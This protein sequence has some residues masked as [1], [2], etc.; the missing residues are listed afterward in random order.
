[1]QLSV[2]VADIRAALAAASRVVERRNT[3]P[4]LS[5]VRLAAEGDRLTI[6]ATDLDLELRTAIPAEI[7]QPGATALPGALLHDIVKKLGKSDR[8]TIAPDGALYR[9]SSGRSKW[10]LNALSESDFPDLTAGEFPT[11]FSLPTASV[12]EIADRLSFAIS[13]EE[14]RY[15]LN[16]VYL[17]APVIAG[18]PKLRAVATDGHRLSRL[19]LDQPEGA[20]AMPGIIIPRKMVAELA[21]LAEAHGK[22]GGGT[23]EVEVSETK[24]RFAFG[25]TILTSKLIDGTFPAYDRVVPIT[26]EHTVTLPRAAF[27]DAVDRVLTVSS[28]RGS[29]V[30]IAFGSDIGGQL[31]TLTCV[32]H[33][34]GSAEEELDNI[35]IAGRPPECGFNARYVLDCLQAIGG[36]RVVL[37]LNEPGSPARL[38]A[39]D[40]DD[41]L[42][43]ALMPMRV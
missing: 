12:K 15:Y 38:H 24:I 29:A 10:H 33:D 8:L 36:D 17:H 22:G 2:A 6:T 4:I 7:G 31:M 13:S 25:D 27:A 19:T 37:G 5:H 28:E 1:M 16:G 32:N 14:T 3:I 35:E 42:L 39:P 43:V 18:E 26:A 41:E 34:A 23:A 21:K 20:G 30:K 11:R 9:L 40:K